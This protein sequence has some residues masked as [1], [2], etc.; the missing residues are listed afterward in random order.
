MRVMRYACGY[1]LFVLCVFCCAIRIVVLRSLHDDTDETMLV[2]FCF[3]YVRV[4]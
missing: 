2:V 4:R 3:V 1:A